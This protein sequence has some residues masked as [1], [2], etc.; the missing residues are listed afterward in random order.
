MSNLPSKMTAIEIAEFGGPE[1]LV[2]VKI[3][4]PSPSTGEVLVK[5]IAAGVSRPDILQRKGKYSPPLGAS[6]ILGL[7]V[8]GEIILVGPDVKRW[9][10]GDKVCGLVSGGGYAEYCLIP[11]PQV[12]PLPS[13][14]NFQQG[15]AL[16]ETYFTVWN[17]LFQ[18]ADLQAGERL[19]VHGGGG[20]IGTTAIQLGS[21]FGAEVYATA[22]SPEKCAAC[23]NLGAVLAENYL[24]GSFDQ[25]ILE[26]TKGEGVDVILDMMGGDYLSRNIQLLRLNGRLAVIAF[27]R[28]KMPE[29][30][31]S[32]LLTREITIFGSTLRSKSVSTKGIIAAQ[33][34]KNVWP[35]LREGKVLPVLDSTFSLSEV[36]DAHRRMESGQHHGKIILEVEEL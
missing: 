26:A 35:L 18:K 24:E 10:I 11:E 12:L 31:I 21:V 22:G 25:M 2:P 8:A 27:L 20:G 34:E 1:N 28:G 29:I 6:N 16:P 3:P 7:E 5:V 32:A 4:I 17:N 19:L 14:L 13:G 9:K 15:A 23:V 36:S 33:L 30:D